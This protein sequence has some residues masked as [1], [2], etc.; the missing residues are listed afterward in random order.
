MFGDVGIH[1]QICIAW[2]CRDTKAVF[3]VHG[4]VH[5]GNVHVRLKFQCI[6][7]AARLDQWQAN[8]NTVIKFGE[9]SISSKWFPP[10]NEL[11]TEK[12][13]G[14]PHCRGQIAFNLC[15]NVNCGPGSSIDIATDL[16]AGQSGDRIPVGARFSAPVQTGPG[17]HQASCT[18]G[19]G[20]FPGVE[21][22][23]GVMLTPHPLLV[24][25]SKKLSRAITLLSL[26]VFV[27]CEKGETT[28]LPIYL[29]AGTPLHF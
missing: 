4:S 15:N 26:R 29:L 25:R 18:M 27:A 28:Y 5:L 6:H 20:S 16:R 7:L 12:V 1:L 8:V 24:P 13:G 3:D 21:S 14:V 23:R 19:T 10:W 17:A 11:A 9:L 2:H 22:G